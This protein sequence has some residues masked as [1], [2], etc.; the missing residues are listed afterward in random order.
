M[1]LVPQALGVLQKLAKTE[2]GA[3]WNGLISPLTLDIE[4]AGK[5]DLVWGMLLEAAP[6]CS[7]LSQFSAR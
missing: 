3:H 2:G 6:T 5:K 4:G 7:E 1:L